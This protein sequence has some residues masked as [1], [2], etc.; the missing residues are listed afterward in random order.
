MVITP[1]L[2]NRL[3]EEVDDEQRAET[4]QELKDSI[5]RLVEE[6]YEVGIIRL[7]NYAGDVI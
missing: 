5:L 4:F 2:E 7:Y 1:H 6:G 3:D